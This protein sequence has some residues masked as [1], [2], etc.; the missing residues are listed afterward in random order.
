MGEQDVKELLAF[1]QTKGIAADKIPGDKK[2]WSLMVDRDDLAQAIKDLQAA[3]LPRTQYANMGEVFR[4]EGFVSSHLEERVRFVYAL[5]EEVAK[6]ISQIDG[7]IVARVHIVVPEDNPL[8]QT[9]SP[10]SASVF[11]KH[12]RQSDVESRIP[13]IKRLV[14]NSVEGLQ[15]DKV[16]VTLFPSETPGRFV[17]SELP[18]SSVLGVRVAANSTWVLW[19]ILGLL[20]T[21][22]MLALGGLVAF[23]LRARKAKA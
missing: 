8:S 22:T 1:L 7:V 20:S 3:G 5:S 9:V 12:E 11:I 14:A 10:S 15:Y 6:T 19:T 18:Y 4:K 23:W 17:S 2:T 16:S 21:T 13:Q